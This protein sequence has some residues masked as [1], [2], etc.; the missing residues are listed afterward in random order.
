MIEAIQQYFFSCS[1][2]VLTAIYMIKCILKYEDKIIRAS[3]IITILIMIILSIANFIYIDDHLR[4]FVSTLYTVICANI[5]F[6]TQIH[7]IAT[8]VICEQL[9]LFLS[10]LIYML[11]IILILNIDTTVLFSNFQG[12][13][14]TNLLVSVIALI[15]IKIKPIKILCNKIINYIDKIKQKN[16]YVLVLVFIIT[17]NVL[18]VIMYFNSKNL[19]MV[20][21]NVVFMIIYSYVA[22]LLLN[23]KN[24]N[25]KFQEENKS[26][27]DNLNEY[28]KMLDYQRVSSHENKNQLLVIKGMVNKNNKKLHNYIDEV[29]NEKRADN[30]TLYTKA[31]RIPSGGLQGLV[32]QK[33]LRMQDENINI[34]L[35]VSSEVRKI[36]LSDF[37]AKVNYDICRVICIIIDNAVDETLKVKDKEISISMYKEEDTFVIEV[38]NKCKDLPDLE[39]IDNKGYTTKETGHGYGLCLL[40]DICDQNKDMTNERMIVGDIFLQVIKI[41]M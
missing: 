35:N 20:I 16:K 12:T 14:I 36:N 41:K 17:L 38:A 3:S 9:I 29:I 32:Y 1:I 13:L 31:K 4:F 34:D 5:I 11:V 15:L 23:E 6:K 2:T 37:N 33:M 10:E 25:I 30:E 7:K 40:K 26:L 19:T 39:K 18:L 24:Q 27:L 28:E 22:Y 21:I 8:A